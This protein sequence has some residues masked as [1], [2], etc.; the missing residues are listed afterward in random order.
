MTGVQNVVKTDRFIN[1]FSWNAILHRDGK[2]YSVS[3]YRKTR[4]TSTGEIMP[5][6]IGIRYE[7]QKEQEWSQLATEHPGL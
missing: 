6:R 2:Y 7:L 1:P 5:E 4:S 3:H